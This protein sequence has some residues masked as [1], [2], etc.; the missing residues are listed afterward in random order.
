LICLFVKCTGGINIVDIIT[1]TAES[2]QYVD[3][4]LIICTLIFGIITLVYAVSEN[5]VVT[6]I[7]MILCILFAFMFIV[8]KG[9]GRQ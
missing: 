8:S 5:Y 4:F 6:I 2:P 9:W 7:S 3:I 1:P